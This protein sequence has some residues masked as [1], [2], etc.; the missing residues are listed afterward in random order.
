M[1]WCE[2]YIGRAIGREST[3]M[4]A[5]KK[6][7]QNLKTQRKRRKQRI[8]GMYVVRPAVIFQANENGRSTLQPKK[9]LC[10]L[11]FLCVSGFDFDF[12]FYSRSFA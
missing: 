5:N 10:F 6:Q 11:R 8:S 7:N 2:Q 9:N 4:N 1:P 3:R 12:V